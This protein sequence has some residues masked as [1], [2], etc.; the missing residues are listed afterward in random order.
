MTKR[1]ILVALAIMLFAASAAYAGD[2]LKIGTAGAQQLRIPIGSR[3]TA[4]GGSAVANSYGLDAIYWNPAGVSTIEGTD[5]MWSNRQYIADIDLNYFAGAKRFG[6][7]GVLGVTAKITSMD[8][9]PVRTVELPE[10]TGAMYSSS[11]AV[12]GLTYSRTLTDRV[13]LGINGNVIYE[14]IAE[15]TATGMGFDIGFHYNPG[16]QN[17]TFGAVIKNLGPKMTY[18][19][20]GFDHNTPTGDDPNSLPH[21]TR[22]RS[23]A[24]EIPSYVQLG[25]AYKLLQQEKNSIDLSGA[26]QSNNFSEDEWHV[27][28]EYALNKQFFLRGGYVASNQ[29][30]Y[31]YGASLGAGLAFN[32]GDTRMQFDY[33]WSASE[34]FDDNQYFTFMVGF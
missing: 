33:A 4:M 22:S 13:A 5:V 27:G 1:L 2:D 25:A 21:T 8:D 28:A 31:L 18:D 23:S 34:F 10:G 9:E 32:L 20:P 14:K 30:E 3:G 17:L 24:F 26:F 7:F 16:W 15:Q 11:F 6:D 29:K 19:G 12:I